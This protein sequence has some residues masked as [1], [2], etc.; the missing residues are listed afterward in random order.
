MSVP[1]HR[2]PTQP[3]VLPCGQPC[4]RLYLHGSSPT[5]RAAVPIRLASKT[6][7]SSSQWPTRPGRLDVEFAANIYVRAPVAHLTHGV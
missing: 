3:R 1:L 7:I 2:N 4:G 5:E 6:L